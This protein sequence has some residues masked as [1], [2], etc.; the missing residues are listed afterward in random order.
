[1]QSMVCELMEAH[2]QHTQT[3]VLLVGPI[4]KAQVAGFT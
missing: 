4:D 1:M 3:H 2:L